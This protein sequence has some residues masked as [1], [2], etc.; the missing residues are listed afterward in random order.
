VITPRTTRLI[1]TRTLHGYRHALCAARECSGPAPALVLVPTRAAA[2]RLQNT[3]EHAAPNGNVSLTTPLPDLLTRSQMYE[4]LVIHAGRVS[5]WLS[6]YDRDAILEAGSHEAVTEGIGPPFNLRPALIGE[7]L[8]LYDA[9]RR[10][11][12]NVE[13]FERLL[14]EELEPHA[15]VDRGAERVLRQTRFLAAAFRSYQRELQ[16]R[17]ALDEHEL[18]DWL[19]TSATAFPWRRVIVSTGD[20]SSERHGLWPADF[21]LLARA[22]GLESIDVVATEAQLAAGLHERIHHLLPGIE[23]VWQEELEDRSRATLVVPSEDSRHFVSRDREEELADV[24]GRLSSA[25]GEPSTAG[26]ERTAIV[27]AR[28]LPYLYVAREVFASAGIPYESDDTLPFAAEPFAAAVDLVLTVV[29]ADADRTAVVALLRSP[30][31]V[32]PDATSELEWETSVAAFNKT[33]T[34]ERYLGGAERLLALATALTSGPAASAAR[35]VRNIVA[36]LQPLFERSSA[37]SQLEALLRFITAHKPE[38]VDERASRA[39]RVIDELLERLIDAYRERPVNWD[40]PQLGAA[41]RRWM[42]AQTFETASG[43]HG[44]CLVDATAARYG[45]FDEVHLVGLVDGE[46]PERRRRNIFYSSMLLK[47]LGWSDEGDPAAPHRA[48]FLD[49]LS[50]AAHRSSVSTFQLEDDALVEP[51]PLLAEL[52]AVDLATEIVS[53]GLPV[54]ADHVARSSSELEWLRL[55]EAGGNFTGPSF[56]GTALPHTRSAYG[57]GSIE[58]Y[59]HCPFKYFARHVLELDEELDD[60]SG[61]T[62][63][64]RGI[65]V[66]EVLHAFFERW[67]ASGKAA[68]T[69]DTLDAALQMLEEVAEPMLQRL[70]SADQS[71]ERA[72]LFGS[73]V[74]PGIGDLVVRMEAERPLAVVGR[75][76]EERFNGTFEL[77]AP[78]EGRRQISLRGIA[79]RIDLLADGS[80]RVLDYKSSVPLLPLQLAIY[81][82]TAVQRLNLD[83]HR[84]W[85]VSEAAYVVYGARRGVRSLGRSRD[86]IARA[87]HAAQVRFVTALDAIQT[88]L[89]PPR[90]VHVRLCASCAYAA[91]CRKDYLLETDESDTPPAV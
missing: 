68:I 17:G 83:E 40:G 16:A 53:T 73:P 28:P 4:R 85:S 90:P 66:H 52:E 72:R 50:L 55:R 8:D 39:R 54:R 80:L 78:E 48:A 49:L 12:Q 76:L 64:D 14:I 2:R 58:L 60:E 82:A 35:T 25:R 6:A 65:F 38:R 71:L 20:R 9:I 24:L 77:D 18:R 63:R 51:S 61:L 36:D 91:I 23:E 67:Q 87:V 34:E 75:R 5:V 33:L 89:F 13:H 44:V 59:A 37:V 30:H 1:R 86:E 29:G 27:F 22:A 10:N 45:T 43:T 46:W 42:E 56:H 69:A 21:D 19:L 41:V 62:P 88:G 15:T 26:L 81:A 70:P 84:D 7:M 47:R 31:F 3:L 32:F 57:V 11:Q 74:A 79:D